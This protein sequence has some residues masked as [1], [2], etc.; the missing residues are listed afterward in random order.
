MR[1]LSISMLL[2][3]SFLTACGSDN[4]GT[5]ENSATLENVN[6]ET[7]EI[8]KEEKVVVNDA[9]IDIVDVFT[10]MKE[11]SKE[12][13]SFAMSGTSTTK[14]T[15]VDVTSEETMEL[16]AE[17]Q[18]EPFVQHLSIAGLSEEALDSEMYVKDSMMYLY[19]WVDG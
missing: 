17:I 15:M 9:S 4:E 11:A 2:L 6:K 3:L 19:S 13:K 5:K 18:L 14:T 7:E 1:N 8:K 10:K 12:I 16:T